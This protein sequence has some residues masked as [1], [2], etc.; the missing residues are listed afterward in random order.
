MAIFVC[1]H[2]T[3]I[4]YHHYADLSEG[5]ELLKYVSCTFC[6]KCVSEIK[7][8]ISTVFHAIY[9]AVH[10]QLTHFSY[11]DCDNTCALSYYY[12]QIGSMTHLPLF[13]AWSWT[14]G[15]CFM[16]FYVSMLSAANNKEFPTC[17]NTHFIYWLKRN[18][19]QDIGNYNCNAGRLVSPD[20][21]PLLLT[22]FIF[23]P[24]MDK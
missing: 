1:L 15:I 6:F 12:H 14:N 17:L 10:I 20:Q 2:I 4:H 18:R 13:R 8:I 22:W 16:S 5:I 9:G 11:Y 24:S 3:L 23:N 19:R 21:W 7:S